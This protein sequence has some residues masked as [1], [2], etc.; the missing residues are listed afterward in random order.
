MTDLPYRLREG[1]GAGL[2][3]PRAHPPTLSRLR[4]W[5]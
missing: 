3:N 2:S 5:E 4:E 1:P